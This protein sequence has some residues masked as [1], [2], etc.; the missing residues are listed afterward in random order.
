MDSRGIPTP[1]TPRR[2]GRCSPQ[3]VRIHHACSLRAGIGANSTCLRPGTGCPSLKCCTLT[4]FRG[5]AGTGAAGMH[6]SWC[7]AMH[8]RM[9]N[10]VRGRQRA[11][12][13]GLCTFWCLAWGLIRRAHLG[14]LD[15]ALD[16]AAL[17]GDHHAVLG[18]VLHLAHAEGLRLGFMGSGLRCFPDRRESHT[19]PNAP[20]CTAGACAPPP[21]CG[22]VPH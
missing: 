10:S 2:L 6:P 15:K 8:A 20:V 13:T 19:Q 9:H 11:Q 4:S 12:G 7:P 22:T 1:P 17:V 16:L 14:L 5:Q 3:C 21:C 18:R